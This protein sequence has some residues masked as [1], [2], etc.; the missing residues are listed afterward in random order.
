M[1]GLLPN[2]LQI[3]FWERMAWIFRGKNWDNS[4][5]I[6]T[7]RDCRK[8]ELYLGSCLSTQ[9]CFGN[10]YHCLKRADIPAGNEV[11]KETGLVILGGRGRGWGWCVPVMVGVGFLS[12][13]T[14]WGLCLLGRHSGLSNCDQC[15]NRHL[16]PYQVLFTFYGYGCFACMYVYV[17]HVCLVFS[18]TRWQW[19]LYCRWL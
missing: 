11:L 19:I 16:S 14:C 12:L 3:K 9:S 5:K 15:K 17:S 10:I 7:S 1:K 2:Y 4:C 18:G 6:L 13:D 8:H